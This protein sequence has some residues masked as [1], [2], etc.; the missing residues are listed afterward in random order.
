MI[1]PATPCVDN[2]CLR[3]ARAGTRGDSRLAAN[4]PE[5]RCAV[6]AVIASVLALPVRTQGASSVPPSVPFDAKTVEEIARTLAKSPFV[7]PETSLPAPLADLQYDQ[8]RDIRFRP[9]A[10]IW[11]KPGRMFGLQLLPLG[12]LFTAPVEIAIVEGGEARHVPYRAD[13]F[14]TG[15]LVTAPLPTQDIG[16]SGFRLVYPI[17]NQAR[18]DEFVVFQGASYFRSLGRDQGYGLS[19]RGLALKTGDPTGEEFPIFRRFWIEAPRPGSRALV[20]HALLDSPSVTGAYRFEI[21]PGHNT[22]MLVG[23]ALFPRVDLK[24]VGLAPGT[25]MFMF[26]ANGRSGADD[27]R[28]QVHDSDGLLM[29]NGRREVLWRPLANPVRLQ[30]SA[31]ED[32]NPRGFGLAQRD[33]NLADYQDFEAHFERRPSLWVEPTGNWG[34]GQVILTEIPSDAEIHDNIVVFW[35]PRKLIPARSEFRLSY[36]LYWG[37]EPIAANNQLRVLAT[38]RGRADVKAPTPVRR[39]VVDYSPGPQACL[40]PCP[41]PRATVT[42]SAGKVQDVVVSDNPITRGYRVSFVLDPEKSDLCELRLD[43]KFDDDR[44]AEVW[45]YR[46]TKP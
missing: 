19:A 21:R 13:L 24:E 23:A 14:T 44:R 11:G 33:R 5:L 3:E 12:Y 27:F 25:S 36:R 41:L 7:P 38:A 34:D 43:L 20:L 31:F 17:N 40:P 37:V 42:A 18:Y 2:P 45:L 32:T 29:F 30:V 9:S 46:W 16:F 6:L 28:P 35:R 8:Y 1:L 4:R 39:F 22:V 10:T 26:S 15:K